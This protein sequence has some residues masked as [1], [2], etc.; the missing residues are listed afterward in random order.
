MRKELLL[1]NNIWIC[2]AVAVFATVCALLAAAIGFLLE[3][4]LVSED[5]HSNPIPI[6]IVFA[7]IVLFVWLMF[8]L[9]VIFSSKIIISDE[10]IK[11]KRFDKT[12]WTIKKHEI[13]KCIYNE[14]HFWRLI[15]NPI[16]AINSGCLQF[17]LQ[18]GKIS[19]HDCLLSKKQV[20]RIKANF[21]YP[22]KDIQ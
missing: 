22:F 5:K 20:D 17:K 7:C 21:D 12:I 9:V 13:S 19:R 10:E 4:I 1:K 14:M 8:L 15:F 16:A 2:L 3:Y 6:I 11:A 18:D